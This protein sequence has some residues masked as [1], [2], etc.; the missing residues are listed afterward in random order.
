MRSPA[1][2]FASLQG[3][4]ACIASLRQGQFRRLAPWRSQPDMVGPLRLFHDKPPHDVI[5]VGTI[6]LL[7]LCAMRL[8]H[9]DGLLAVSQ[10]AAP[11]SLPVAGGCLLQ[12]TNLPRWATDLF[13]G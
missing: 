4:N 1:Y 3:R 13:D 2:R 9:D 7:L 5:I 11:P 6:H 12:E 8:H 10:M